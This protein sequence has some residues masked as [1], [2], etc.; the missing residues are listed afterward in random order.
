MMDATVELNNRLIIISRAWNLTKH[1]I[2]RRMIPSQSEWSPDISASHSFVLVVGIDSFRLYVV[3]FIVLRQPTPWTLE[4]RVVFYWLRCN[5]ETQQP[6]TSHG[7]VNVLSLVEAFRGRGVIQIYMEGRKDNPLIPRMAEQWLV[8]RQEALLFV[9]SPNSR[10]D[11]LNQSPLSFSLFI[12]HPLLFFF[13][14]F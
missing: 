4:F 8:M 7:K 2:R 5:L 13:G 14:I 3:K 12:V 10:T 1:P 9:I 6:T 11:N